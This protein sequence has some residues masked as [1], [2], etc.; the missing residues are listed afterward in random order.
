MN[1][2]HLK[3]PAADGYPL[4]ATIYGANEEREMKL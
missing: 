1:V 2:K 4:A 3:L